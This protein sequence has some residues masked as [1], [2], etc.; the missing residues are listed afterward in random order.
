[1]VAD[2]DAG[3]RGLAVDDIAD[4][5]PEGVETNAR[6]WITQNLRDGTVELARIN[7]GVS[8]PIDDPLAFSVSDIGGRIDATGVTVHYLRPM[9]PV[10]GVNAVGTFDE[11]GF[12]VD[13]TSGSVR[14]MKLESGRIRI[15]G[16]DGDPKGHRINIDLTIA[17]AVRGALELLDQKPLQF[18]RRVDIA[19]KEASGNHR[20]QLIV[21]FPLLDALKFEDIRVAAASRLNGF[22]LTRGPMGLP[23]GDGDLSLQIDTEKMI[24]DGNVGVSGVPAGVAWTEWFAGKVKARRTYQVRAILNDDA[25]ARLGLDLSPWLSGPVGIGLTY[26]EATIGAV[27]GAAE[28]DAS[29]AAMTVDEVGWSK[30]AGVPARAFL[31]FSGERGQIRRFDRFTM[32]AADLVVE[33]SATLRATAGAGIAPSRVTL[34]RLAFGGTDLFGAA[35]FATDGSVDVSL[36]GR[37]LDLRREV[38]AVGEADDDAAATTRPPRPIRIDISKAAPIGTVRLGEKTTLADLRG[39]LAVTGTEIRQASL[40]AD[41]NG[42]GAVTLDIGETGTGRDVRFVA[43]DGGD[44]IDAFEVTDTIL[45]GRLELRGTIADAREPET[46]VG[47]LQLTDFRLTENSGIAR[48]FT[49]ASFSGAGDAVRDNGLAM[50]LAEVPLTFSRDEIVIT[51]AKLR[52]ADVGVLATGRIDRKTD[53]IAL[54]GE[55]APA[56]TL[57]SLL[58]NIPLIGTLLTGGGDGVFAASYEITGPLANPDVRVNPLTVL[59]PGII[60]RLLTGFGS[61]NQAAPADGSAPAIP[62]SPAR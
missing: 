48:A 34:K 16:L 7:V 28:I 23:L 61:D 26:S 40:V 10:R 11:S 3:L 42:K 18:V 19:P 27:S 53:T 41:L 5:W 52:G 50:Q 6:T 14:Q 13:A 45:G 17:G 36:G 35:E 38:A 29:S 12:T 4:W 33:G 59:T 32:S 47:Q 55:V 58:G 46:F 21:Q 60:R 37:Q 43:Q 57:N 15:A 20:T 56:Y 30:S 25:R 51:E 62:Q 44:L 9:D 2:F 39:T 31:R 49:L 22:A 54:A 1:M 24:V 8:M